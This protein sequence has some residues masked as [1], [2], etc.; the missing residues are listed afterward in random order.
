MRGIAVPAII[1]CLRDNDAGIRRGAIDASCEF[2]A[3]KLQIVPLLVA[4]LQDSD[5]NLRE[6]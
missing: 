2:K 3:T 4:S 5:N 6:N 1:A